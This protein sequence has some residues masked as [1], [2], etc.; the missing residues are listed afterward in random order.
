VATTNSCRAW[1]FATVPLANGKHRF[2]PTAT[3]TERGLS[4][5]HRPRLM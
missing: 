5:Q 1:N 4:A 3:E 2:T